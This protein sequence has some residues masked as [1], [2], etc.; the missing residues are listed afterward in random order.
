MSIH[1]DTRFPACVEVSICQSCASRVV[2]DAMPC[3][4]PRTW[5][6]PMN[7][8]SKN[9]AGMF[10]SLE[11][12][13]PITIGAL[14][15]AVVLTFGA[16]AYRE[17]W[18]SA[19]ESARERMATTSRTVASRLSQVIERRGA[20]LVTLAGE[21]AIRT[22][23]LE[24]DSK[25]ARA[26]AGQQL[27]EVRRR[28]ADVAIESIELR[29]AGGQLLASSSTDSVNSLDEVALHSTISQLGTDSIRVGSLYPVGSGLYFWYV[30]P[31]VHGGQRIGYVTER[32]RFSQVSQ[33]ETLIR[34]FTDLPLQLYFSSRGSGLWAT[35]KG[36]QLQAPFSTDSAEAEF[37][38]RIADTDVLGLTTPIPGSPWMLIYTVPESEITARAMLLFDRVSPFALGLLLF[39]CFA[40][41]LISRGVIRPLRT[42]ASAADAIADGDY[43]RRVEQ[44][45]DEELWQLASAFNRMAERVGHSHHE[46]EARNEEL[47][48]AQMDAEN[49]RQTSDVARIE[50]QRA[51]EAKT[52]FLAMMSHELRTPLSAIGGYTEILQLGLRGPLTE[53]QLADLERIRSNQGHLLTI[54]NDMLDLSQ[55]ESGQ[56]S[57]HCES[58]LLDDVLAQV[59]PIVAPHIAKKKL[60]YVVDS[61]VRELR[62]YADRER[63]RQVL[64]N[65]VTNA[66][67]YSEA[68]GLINVHAARTNGRVSLHVSDTGI[69]IPAEKLD[70]IFE[71]FVQV[72]TGPTRRS[73]GTGLGLPISRRLVEAMEGSLHVVSEMGVGS[74]FTLE[75]KPADTVQ[76]PELRLIQGRK[77]QIA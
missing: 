41:W 30:V 67:R 25:D 59:E 74:T 46:L 32:R 15:A 22:A 37:E 21:P 76:K 28:L 49:A 60:T 51:N 66:A 26:V 71:P 73:G 14:L 69:G 33:F 68:G 53:T 40:G 52:S 63:L 72:D 27:L 36:A 43:S 65:I 29:D 2:A 62:V 38:T 35:P 34:E 77:K 24:S 57:V 54:I 11:R 17:V 70:A 4:A 8:T 23:L 6:G 64:V 3:E 58:V 16:A 42:L 45:A 75:L 10:G 9:R 61:S 20:A 1:V 44:P 13:L 47:R 39:G 12:R 18:S 19:R 31:A 48:S 55:I 7:E 5:R 56:L 50:A